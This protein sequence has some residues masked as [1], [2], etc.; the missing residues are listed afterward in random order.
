MKN[1]IIYR[2]AKSSWEDPYLDDHLRPLAERGLRDAPRM[3]QRLKKGGI[4]PDHFLSSDAERAK[5]TAY[6][7]AENLHFPK[8]EIVLAPV[9]YH[10]SA[11]TILK[12]IQ[13]IP[14][15]KHT[16]LVFGHNPGFNELI[17]KL[18]GQIDNLPTCGQFGF[19]FDADNWKE[20]G[21][22]NAKVWFVDYPKKQ[23]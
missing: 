3:A 13:N 23:S 11:N 21:Q 8:N 7:T 2:H 12:T 10:A 14:N 5:A 19:I 18:G 17:W 6:I 16:A 20:I 15:H 22:K 1:L 9:L 4:S